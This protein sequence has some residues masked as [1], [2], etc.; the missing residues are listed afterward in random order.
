CLVD[1]PEYPYTDDR[2]YHA[3]DHSTSW[4]PD[5]Q[6]CPCCYGGCVGKLFGVAC[7]QYKPQTER[8]APPSAAGIDDLVCVCQDHDGDHLKHHHGHVLPEQRPNM[9]NRVGSQECQ[10]GKHR[11]H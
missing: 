1:P 2:E 4:L 9:I 5:E 3:P 6:K 8:Q 10:P 11:N 7:G